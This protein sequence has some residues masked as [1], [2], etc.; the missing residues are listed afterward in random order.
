MYDALA[1][2][3]HEWDTGSFLSS[4]PIAVKAG[5]QIASFAALGFAFGMTGWEMAVGHD[6]TGDTH[7]PDGCKTLIAGSCKVR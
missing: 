7:G 2:V 4:T 6:G 1:F 3:Q 5:F